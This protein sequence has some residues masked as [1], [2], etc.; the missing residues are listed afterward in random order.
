LN[1]LLKIGIPVLVAVLLLVFGAGLVAAQD[2]DISAPINSIAYDQ[3]S[4]PCPQFCPGSCNGNGDC[5]YTGN[6][7][8]IC[9]GSQGQ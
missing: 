2:K 6:C 5:P 9:Q 8:G 4:R 3:G 1:K 7:S